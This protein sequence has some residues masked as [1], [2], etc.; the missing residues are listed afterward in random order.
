MAFDIL[1]AGPLAVNGSKVSC[2]GVLTLKRDF[3]T[4]SVGQAAEGQEELKQC[5]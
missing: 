5:V 1:S 4:L 2:I 3:R